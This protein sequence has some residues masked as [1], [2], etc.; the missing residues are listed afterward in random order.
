MDGYRDTDDV[1]LTGEK[2]PKTYE[3]IR[4][5]IRAACAPFRSRRVH[6]G[7][8]E[9]YWMGRGLYLNLSLIHICSPAVVRMTT[10]ITTTM[11]MTMM[12]TETTTI[13]VTTIQTT[14]CHR[15]IKLEKI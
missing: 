8:D 3:F 5:C 10:T 7:M 12:M 11:A 1:L 4:Q 2:E 14:D 13:I 15:K 9:A 6:I